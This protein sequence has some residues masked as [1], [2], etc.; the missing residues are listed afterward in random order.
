MMQN[1]PFLWA[2][3]RC[4]KD[5]NLFMFDGTFDG[6]PKLKAWNNSLAWLLSIIA[7]LIEH[8]PCELDCYHIISWWVYQHMLEFDILISNW[9]ISSRVRIALV[10][11]REK[12]HLIYGLMAMAARTSALRFFLIQMSWSLRCRYIGRHTLRSSSLQIDE[13][14]LGWRQQHE[15]P[16][17]PQ[18]LSALCRFLHDIPRFMWGIRTTVSTTN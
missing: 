13:P 14:R 6:A 10:L 16:L 2:D 11:P 8:C 18:P 5:T 12:Q 1:H 9:L 3:Q 4:R 7:S 15:E 17:V